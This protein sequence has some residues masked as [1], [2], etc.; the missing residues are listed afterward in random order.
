MVDN[1]R[2]NSSRVPSNSVVMRSATRTV[3]P[4]CLAWAWAS[5]KADAF[6]FEQVISRDARH[7]INGQWETKE[8]WVQNLI[9]SFWSLVF[10]HEFGHSL[11]L[12]HNFMASVDKN[13]FPHFK[14]GR[15]KP[16]DKTLD[17]NFARLEPV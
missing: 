14:D 2:S 13:N 1:G 16:I 10:Y 17:T 11:G 4:L 9:H 7:C 5:V 15:G 12:D 3:R 8:Q 6:S